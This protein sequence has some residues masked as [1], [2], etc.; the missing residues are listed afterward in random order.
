ME[1]NREFSEPALK[2]GLPLNTS[3]PHCVWGR[4]GMVK[5]EKVVFFFFFKFKAWLDTVPAS[6]IAQRGFQ[7][8]GVGDRETVPCDST[9]AWCWNLTQ[10]RTRR[11]RAMPVSVGS[12]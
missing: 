2:E 6:A 5:E 11:K 7:E 1:I 4:G 3:T 8:H 9:P 12:P 10:M